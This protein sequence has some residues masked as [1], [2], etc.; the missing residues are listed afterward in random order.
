MLWRSPAP[1]RHPPGFIEPCLP[2]LGHTVPSSL[3]DFLANMTANRGAYGDCCPPCA[4]IRLRK[5]IG[6]GHIYL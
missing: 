2:T 5:V 4:L 1:V 3:A 6:A